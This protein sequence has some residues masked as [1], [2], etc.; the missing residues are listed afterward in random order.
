MNTGSGGA[1]TVRKVL[2]RLERLAPPEMKMDFDNVGLLAGFPDARVSGIL[3]S[4]DITDDVIDEAAAL[5]A[6]LVVSHHPLFF[7][8]KNVTAEPGQGGRVVKLIAGGMSA[9]CMHTNLDAAIGGVNDALAEAAGLV[10]VEL[11][12]EHGRTTSGE[13]FSYGRRGRLRSPRAM[14]EYLEFLKG[15]LGTSGLRYYDAGRP[16]SQVA[17][18]GGSGGSELGAA[19]ARGCDTLLTA[20]VKYD[21]FLEARERG[22]NLIDGDHF[23]TENTVVPGLAEA[24]REAFPSVNTSIS[25]RHGQTVK[26]K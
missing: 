11:L 25:K 15:R 19:A 20:D 16:V 10:D 4:L 6:E 18:V 9:I 5:G 24:L 1:P 14:G 21:V 2:E 13:S 17:V 8:L 7:S 3:V 12:T 23:C 22:V 26:F